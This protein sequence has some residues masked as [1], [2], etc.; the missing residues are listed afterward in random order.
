VQIRVHRVIPQEIPA[1]LNTDRN[2]ARTS[3]DTYEFKLSRAKFFAG[4]SG[5]L[6][7]VARHEKEFP[8]FQSHGI[9][10][11]EL[12]GEQGSLERAQ[13][14]VEFFASIPHVVNSNIESTCG[15]SLTSFKA[16][17]QY[18]TFSAFIDPTSSIFARNSSRPDWHIRCDY[19]G[20]G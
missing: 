7:P 4:D 12:T 18:F 6:R 15:E 1:G 5:G 3:L 16:I 14:G 20:G 13:T 10:L 8:L 19:F 11:F 9:D 17:A 2:Q